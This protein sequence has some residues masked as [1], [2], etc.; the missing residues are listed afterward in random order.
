MDYAASETKHILSNN[1]SW[2]VAAWALLGASISA[3]A[4]VLL[5]FALITLKIRKK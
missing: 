2:D 3:V 5:V 1:A 4:L